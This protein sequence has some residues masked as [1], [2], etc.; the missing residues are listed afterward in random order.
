[1]YEKWVNQYSKFK[2][3]I[4]GAFLAYVCL[5][6][7]FINFVSDVKTGMLFGFVAYGIYN[8]TNFATLQ[9]YPVNMVMVD[10]TYG[11]LLFGLLGY[12]KQKYI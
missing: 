9:K 6:I 3:N 8:F 11:V 2:F 12:L 10:I 4:L 1:M 7:G 5:A